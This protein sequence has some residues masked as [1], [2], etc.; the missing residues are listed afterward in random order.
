MTFNETLAATATNAPD[1]APEPYSAAWW[2]K[3]SA[4]ELRDII[5]RGFAGGQAFQGAVSETERRAR[6][7]TRRLRD[8][9][10]VEAEHRRKRKKAMVL[11]TITA[12]VTIAACAGLWVAG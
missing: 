1:Q 10:V 2:D 5:K 7:E 4:E 9:A 11:V 3:R 12:A 6:E 8:L